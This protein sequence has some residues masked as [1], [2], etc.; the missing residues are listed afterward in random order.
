M[1]EYI[2]LGTIIT[3]GYIFSKQNKKENFIAK[4]LNSHRIIMNEINN[5]NKNNNAGLLN[6]IKKYNT[7]MNLIR[8]GII[9]DTIFC[10]KITQN[11]DVDRT[12]TILNTYREQV[13]HIE[14][15]K[16]LHHYLSRKKYIKCIWISKF[17]E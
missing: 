13:I 12:K 11:T 7:Q 8:M 5:K 9:I 3:L 15:N 2:V 1:A 16:K 4:D 14:E 17:T 6:T 10:S